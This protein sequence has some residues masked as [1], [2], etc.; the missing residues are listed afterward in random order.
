MEPGEVRSAGGRLDAL[1]PA[2]LVWAE[3]QRRTGPPWAQLSAVS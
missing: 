1:S 3:P 2:A